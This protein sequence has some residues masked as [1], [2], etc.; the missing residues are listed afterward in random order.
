[1]RAP[2]TEP[3]PAHVAEALALIGRAREA[4]A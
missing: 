1:V 2:L 4:L 3:D